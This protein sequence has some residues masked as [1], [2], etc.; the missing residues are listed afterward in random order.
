MRQRSFVL[1]GRDEAG[2][3]AWAEFISAATA[4]E[5]VVIARSRLPEPLQIELWDGIVCA[6]REERAA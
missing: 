6:Y 2:R 4:P 3:A 1:Y 5:A